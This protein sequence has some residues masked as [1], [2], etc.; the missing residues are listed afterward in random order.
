MVDDWHGS[1]LT[2]CCVNDISTN[3]IC[4][5]L[6]TTLLFLHRVIII[7]H[8]ISVV[9]SLQFHTVCHF[10]SQGRSYYDQKQ[11]KTL[12]KKLS[13][14]LI[15][16]IIHKLVFFFYNWIIFTNRGWITYFVWCTKSW[17]K[18]SA[19]VNMT[20]NNIY[21]IYIVFRKT[22]QDAIFNNIISFCVKY[23]D[24]HKEDQF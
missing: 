10:T 6:R 2:T 16:C 1:T 22:T 21:I 5:I 15:I 8:S 13:N 19:I 18:K 20:R 24:I 17:D 12:S 3:C 7:L 14:F 11:N 9:I 4:I 23:I